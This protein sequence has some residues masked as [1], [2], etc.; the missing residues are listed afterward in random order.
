MGQTNQ[1]KTTL[2]MPDSLFKRAR[3][4]ARKR[5]QT[6]T[7]FFNAAVEAK[8]AADQTARRIRPWMA[9]AGVTA[10]DRD[11]SKRILKV[12]DE[13]CERIDEAEWT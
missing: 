3:A 13:E 1:M 11:E 9:Y 10:A 12:I 7:S 5:G 8:L 6:M 4:A 2:E